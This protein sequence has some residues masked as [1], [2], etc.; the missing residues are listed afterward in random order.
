MSKVDLS[1]FG[2]KEQLRQKQFGKADRDQATE[3]LLRKP[4]TDVDVLLKKLNTAI[5]DIVAN[6]IDPN[7][8]RVGVT[9]DCLPDSQKGDP[10]GTWMGI[11]AYYLPDGATPEVIYGD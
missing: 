2:L 9:Q 3:R 8:L 5:R 7:T 11:S 4:D 6:N 1:E 10:I